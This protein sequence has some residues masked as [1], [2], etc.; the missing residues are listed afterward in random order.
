MKE[1]F[2][3]YGGFLSSVLS[4]GAWANVTNKKLIVPVYHTVVNSNADFIQPLYKPIDIK[5]FS[6]DLEF[7][8]KHF[9]PISIEGAL[10]ST[11]TK[12]KLK[13][14][15]FVLTFDNGLSGV[16]QYVY[17]ILR[18][19]GIPAIVFLNTDFVD[20]RGLFYRFKAALIIQALELQPMLGKPV[21]AL[22]KDA[23]IAEKSIKGQLLNIKYKQSEILDKI[24]PVCD[25]DINHF[26]ETEK[27]YLTLPQIRE[28]QQ[29]GVMF[30]SHG[31]NHA[32][33]QCLSETERQTQLSDSLKWI[34]SNC[35]QSSKLFAFPFTDSG[36]E[37]DYILKM[38]QEKWLDISFGCSGIN[39]DVLPTHIQ[40]IP[41][42]KEYAYSAS[43]MI[44]TEYLY[45]SLKY[46]SGK[47][48]VRS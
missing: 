16:Y 30:G 36:I 44:K 26:L 6:S 2:F 40:R 1:M 42:E 27:P 48:R 19:K 20:N 33:F 38:H 14:P 25:I 34:E 8:L 31:T 13:K 7:L 29:N 9:E 28:M 46:L 35:P 5:R 43:K 10:Q 23:G 22:L 41:M 45:Y 32:E 21:S 11:A 18:Q 3:K 15:S 17:P 37:S 24:L 4:T 39:N 47:K 12:Q